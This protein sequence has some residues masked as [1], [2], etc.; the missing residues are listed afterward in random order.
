[1]TTIDQTSAT[2]AALSATDRTRIVAH[3]NED[4]GDSVL[5][6]ARH[7]GARPAATAATIAALDPEGMDLVVTEPAGD[8]AVRISFSPTLADATDAHNT[9][10]RL[11]RE[12]AAALRAATPSA[13]PD[14]KAAAALERARTAVFFLRDT[15]KTIQLGTVAASGEPDC[16]VAPY[17]VTAGGD[18]L[19]YISELSL[20]TANLRANGRAT[21]LLIEDETTAGHLLARRRLTLATRAT[22]VA[23][24]HEAFDPCMAALRE[25][26]GPV[27]E[28]LE[29]MH[30]FHLV[31]LAPE[32]ARL[33]AGFGQA[34]DV[35]PRDWSRL[36]HVNDT[37]HS[38]APQSHKS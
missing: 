25:R 1:M 23:R 20:H 17:V 10:V 4:H 14:A 37:G 33:V 8:V 15:L 34:Y 2:D 31:C 12:S 9:L 32:R 29:K 26:F 6:Y 7:L 19:T 22:F 35:D 3:M 24:E 21:V 36:G 5:G 27:M 28:H 16:S 11:A 38:A 18:M 13:A 30:D